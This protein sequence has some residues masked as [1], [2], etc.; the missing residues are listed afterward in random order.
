MPAVSV[1]T[2]VAAQVRHGVKL[3]TDLGSQRARVIDE[4]GELLAVYR[5]DGRLARAEVVVA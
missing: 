4:T 5:Q 3:D 1:D 2:D